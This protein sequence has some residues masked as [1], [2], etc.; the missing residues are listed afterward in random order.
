M[1]E[2]EVKNMP[3]EMDAINKEK[4]KILGKKLM[5]NSIAVK[6]HQQPNQNNSIPNPNENPIS[7]WTLTSKQTG[8]PINPNQQLTNFNPVLKL[9]TQT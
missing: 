6:N 1:L 2:Q 8:A 4:L 3:K 5:K 7:P 9:D